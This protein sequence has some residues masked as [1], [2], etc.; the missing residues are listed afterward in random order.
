MKRAMVCVLTLGLAGTAVGARAESSDCIT[1]CAG[2]RAAD[3]ACCSGGAGKVCLSAD[4]ITVAEVARRLSDAIGVE[5]RVQGPAFEKL[6]LKVCASTPE[7]ALAQVATALHA[8][9]RPAYVFG[10]GPAPQKP[11][12]SE[13]AVTV[14]F[15]SAPAAS[16][17]FVT[18]AQ[19]GG[20][21]IADRPL[22]GKVT[23]QGKGVPASMILDAI[24]V[25]A[26][27]NWKPAYVLQT[28]PETLVRRYNDP[29]RTAE[30]S[31]LHTRPGSPLS[32]LHRGPNG[33]QSIAPAP[34]M[35]VKDP[36]A[37]IE[38][39]EKE[40]LRRHELGEWAGIFTQETPR[41][42][43]RAI[44]DLRIRVET[45][46]QKLESYPPQNRQLGMEMW[47]A[48]YERM[49]DDY[50]RLAPDQ[51]KQVQPVLDAMKYFAAPT[52]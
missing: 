36:A 44:R 42:T 25:A 8:H 21:L 19:A 12:G 43:K 15:R 29:T 23:I 22:T 13:S 3:A 46:I 47:R 11:A 10:S 41:D 30:G 2:T 35:L 39:L 9:W 49:L 4:G 50:K 28:G 34:G 48:R 16:A 31:G 51:Q 52:N 20:V 1:R 6:T 18:A 27:L 7:A 33:E 32:H 26:G 40:A 37:E 17:A 5:V 45:T 24:A 38:R 14:T